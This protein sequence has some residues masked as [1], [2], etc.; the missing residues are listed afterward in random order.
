[1]ITIQELWWNNWFSYGEDNSLPMNSDKLTQIVGVNGSGKSSIPLILEEI[2]YSKNSKDVSKADL[3]NRYSDKKSVEGRVT[4]TVGSDTYE[5]QVQRK[6]TIK[7]TLLKNGEDIS[8]HTSKGTYSTLE[9]ILGVDFKTFS[10][11]V[12][13]SSTSSLQFLTATDANRKAFLINLF[14]LEEYTR[15][16]N[17]FK[18]E[19]KVLSKNVAKIEGE[20]ATLQDW[21]DRNR[22]RDL[23]E[24]QLKEIPKYEEDY[25]DKISGLS[26]ELSTVDEHNKAVNKNRKY[27]E[28]RDKIN[29]DVIS[30]PVQKPE[31]NSREY[32]SEKAVIEKSIQ[33]EQKKLSKLSRLGDVCP[34]CEQAVDKEIVEAWITDANAI[35][36]E[37]NDR[38]EEIN[39]ILRE[40]RKKNV[41]YKEYRDTVDEFEKLSNYIDDDLPDEIRDRDSIEEQIS[42]L[43]TRTAK[44]QKEIKAATEYNEKASAHNSK[45]GVIREQLVDYNNRLKD[46]AKK[47]EKQQELLN[48]I[49]VLKKSFSNSGLVSYKIE[50]LI[51]DLEQQINSYLTELSYGRFQIEFVLKGEKLNIEILDNGNTISIK[52]LSAGEL[53]RVNVSTL[54]AIRKLM[55]SISATRLNVLF[56]DEIMGVLDAEGKDKLITILLNEDLNTFIVSHEY[57]HPLMKKVRVVKEDNFSKIEEIE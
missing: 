30:N 29:P 32:T 47:L 18:D 17:L 12:Y 57:S 27:K 19:V 52:A 38:L 55:A 16:H 7:I 49:E 46:A 53:A 56:L 14:N 11:L 23:K 1:M 42:E 48:V 31:E 34:H 50:Y 25:T 22:D 44:L 21:I 37:H 15:L 40:L 20:C 54:L 35:I 51:K 13:Q 43:K 6:S 36:E 24:I 3:P 8:S 9:A 39:K 4:F 33:D 26:V 28:L 10:Q 5:V 2:L 45:V 41:K